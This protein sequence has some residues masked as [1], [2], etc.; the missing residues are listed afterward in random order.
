MSES[1][2]IDPLPIF[3]VSLFLSA[4]IAEERR[5]LEARI[6]Q[7]EEEL[8]EEQCNTELV[9]DRLKKAM[10]Q[11]CREPSEQGLDLVWRCLP[12]TS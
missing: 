4:Q 5:R 12:A 3:L 6:A 11:V 1:A 7:L 8:E 2:I 10:L 9:N